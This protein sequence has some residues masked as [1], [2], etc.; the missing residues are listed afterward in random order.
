M[1]EKKAKTVPVRI[2]VDQKKKLT[3]I[4]KGDLRRGITISIHDHKILNQYP[5]DK[6]MDDLDVFMTSLQRRR[7]DVH[8]NHL[9][10]LPA[11][12]R[13]CL[14]KDETDL[15]YFK[16]NVIDKKKEE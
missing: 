7:P 10:N 9:H 15:S 4:G 2:F 16:D 1:Y 5:D 11:F 8:S 3:N 13:T 12:V 6:V 14:K